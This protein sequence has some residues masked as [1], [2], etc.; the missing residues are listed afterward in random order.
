MIVVP[1]M[2]LKGGVGKTTVVRLLAPE[3]AQTK[4]VLAI[5]LDP[6]GMLSANFGLG[7]DVPGTSIDVL[8]GKPIES[9]R[10]AVELPVGAAGALD[11]VAANADLGQGER[12]AS[13][14]AMFALRKAI[15]QLNPNE[16]DI[17]LIDATPNIGTLLTNA[18][19]VADAVVIVAE[20]SFMCYGP[21]IEL[22]QTLSALGEE[23]DRKF[24]IAGLVLNRVQTTQEHAVHASMLREQLPDAVCSTEIRLRTA[25][26][27]AAKPANQS[28]MDAYVRIVFAELAKELTERLHGLYVTAQIEKDIA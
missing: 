17:V 7:D 16:Y 27:K 22:Y 19:I 2:N 10:V 11:I 8:E 18:M 1:V 13:P 6:H 25:I 24:P 28:V 26:A 23:L 14:S 5:D 20:P 12:N 9:V 21:T 3:L 15:R 4:R